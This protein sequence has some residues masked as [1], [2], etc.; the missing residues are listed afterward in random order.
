[1]GSVWFGDHGV[2][3]YH[4]GT[5]HLGNGHCQGIYLRGSFFAA[6]AGKEQNTQH[7]GDTGHDKKFV[8]KR[9]HMVGIRNKYVIRSF[10]DIKGKNCA[11]PYICRKIFPIT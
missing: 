6:I 1:M 4:T 5:I 3:R 2:Y 10:F 8:Y 11:N 9:L 7:S